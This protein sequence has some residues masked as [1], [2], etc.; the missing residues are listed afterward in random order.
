MPTITQKELDKLKLKQGVYSQL[1]QSPK[2]HKEIMNLQK[3][4]I[5]LIEK[6][7]REWARKH[8]GCTKQLEDDSWNQFNRILQKYL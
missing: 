3:L 1:R 7:F 8:K 4:V 5:D 6:A 2:V